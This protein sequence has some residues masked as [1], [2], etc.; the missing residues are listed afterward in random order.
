M[1]IKRYNYE[2]VIPEGCI[3]V[4]V[5][6]AEFDYETGMFSKDPEF[7]QYYTLY[8]I[9]K[10]AEEYQFIFDLW[11]DHKEEFN[12]T[13]FIPEGTHS[14]Y[15]LLDMWSAY[16]LINDDNSIAC[17]EGLMYLGERIGD[18]MTEED[19]P[20][21]WKYMAGLVDIRPTFINNL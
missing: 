18:H 11:E 10:R 21:F 19:E 1:G 7:F 4:T 6:F 16:I 20:I 14:Q 3:G 17:T 5:S 9:S 8:F 2:D 12:F 13:G 15:P